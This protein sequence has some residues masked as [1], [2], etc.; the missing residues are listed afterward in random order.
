MQTSSTAFRPQWDQ[1]SKEHIE[2]SDPLHCQF[3]DSIILFVVSKPRHW[4]RMKVIFY[5]RDGYWIIIVTPLFTPLCTSQLMSCINIL[6]LYCTVN[7]NTRINLPYNM[8]KYL[9]STLYWYNIR[10]LSKSVITKKKCIKKC[11]FE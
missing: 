4:G 10:I 11:I 9:N 2:R 6:V 7:F 8:Q 5:S 1:N 3:S